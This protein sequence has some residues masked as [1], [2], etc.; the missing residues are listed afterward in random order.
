MSQTPT[1]MSL[2][3]R[4]EAQ[5]ISELIVSPILRDLLP[6][7]QASDAKAKHPR[8]AVV[9]TPGREIS[10]GARLY[11]ISGSVDLYFDSSREG[12]KAE[13]MDVAASR[14]EE[15]LSVAQAR[16]DYGLIIDG[17]QP[18]QTISDHIRK[19]SFAFRLIAG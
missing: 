1:T 2:K 5:L 13:Q 16:G 3:E 8:I 18:M 6:K 15:C 9:A 4:C 10:P 11:N 17:E 14:I 7:R 19:R 12:Q